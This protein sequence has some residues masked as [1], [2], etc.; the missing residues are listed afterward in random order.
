MIKLISKSPRY[1]RF[2]LY[3]KYKGYIFTSDVI[4]SITLEIK[5][6]DF[7]MLFSKVDKLYNGNPTNQLLTYFN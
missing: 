6:F 5:M 4:F 7:Y 1:T 3:T 2:V